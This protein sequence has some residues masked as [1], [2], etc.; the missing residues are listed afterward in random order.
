MQTS[1]LLLENESL[2]D[3]T[4]QRIIKE[5]LIRQNGVLFAHGKFS[6]VYRESYSG[7]SIIAPNSNWE[8]D[9]DHRGYLPVEWWIMSLVSAENE[10]PLKNEGLTHLQLI[11]DNNGTN[12]DPVAVIVPLKK[13]VQLCENELLGEYKSRWPLTKILD[14]GG[15]PVNP[16]FRDRVGEPEVPPIPCHIH[17]GYTS[18]DSVTGELKITGKPGKME[19]YFFPPLDMTPYN[20]TS[21]A[22]IKTRLGLK[23]YI[24]KQDVLHKLKM[25]G[26]DDSFYD[27]LSEYEI[28][29]F[30]GWTILPGVL[31]APGPYLTFEVQYAQ[32]D[33]HFA[34]WKL[35]NRIFDASKRNK[36]K[37][38]LQLRGLSDEQEFIDV[39]VNWDVTSDPKFKE[40]Y[41]RRSQTIQEGSWG[42][43]IQIFFDHFYGEG[44]E[45]LPNQIMECK[46][47]KPF[48]GIV[49]S[50][51]GSLNE[52]DIDATNELQREF[53]IVPNTPVKIKNTSTS[54]KLLI[55][56]VFPN[57]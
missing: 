11:N 29:P 27:I 1:S 41:Y 40:K 7:Q 48:A 10:I 14:I 34:S 5:T 20:R 57:Q 4:L 31:H 52:N 35:G 43:R 55:W 50:G 44:F 39:L 21:T 19:A 36:L 46:F 6:Y 32:D 45:V 24:T 2:D 25:F 51:N 26:I 12:T 8:T 18:R 47:E 13:A 56:T 30:D 37:H 15:T 54:D 28:K 17:S 9:A 33:F 38:S 23:P 49:W 53:L 22:N 16:Q 42:K 3:V